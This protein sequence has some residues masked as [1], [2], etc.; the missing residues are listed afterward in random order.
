MLELF[1]QI[2]FNPDLTIKTANDLARNLLGIG[3]VEA[4]VYNLKDI[5]LEEYPI[6]ETLLENGTA[7]ITDNVISRDVLLAPI[8][9]PAFWARANFA[10]SK[11]E[12]GRITLES[13]AFLSIDEHVRA[14]DSGSPYAIL[15]DRLHILGQ[16]VCYIQRISDKNILYVS[17]NV[18]DLYGIPI[19]DLYRG[20]NLKRNVIYD[21]QFFDCM[22]QQEIAT[23]SQSSYSFEYRVNVNGNEKIIW[24]RGE[25]IL[26][27]GCYN[28]LYLNVLTDVT[29]ERVKD[30]A[31]VQ[32][33]SIKNIAGIT[34]DLA[35]NFNNIL[36][37]ITLN[38]GLMLRG[39][40]DRD[41]ID[42]RLGVILRVADRARDI[43]TSLMAISRNQ[44]LKPVRFDLNQAI[45][46]MKDLI[47]ASAGPSIK[48]V[49]ELT[50]I[51]CPVILDNS[52]FNQAIFN[53]LVNSRQAM[54]SG[55]T[56]TIS[57][58][59]R[60]HPPTLDLALP[61]AEAR[62]YAELIIAD[63][64]PG[65]TKEV[66]EHALEPYFTTKKAQGGSGIGLAATNGFMIQSGGSLKLENRPGGGL[67]VH[68]LFPL[69][70]NNGIDSASSEK[71]A[72]DRILS[73]LVVDDDLDLLENLCDV[74]SMAGLECEKASSI[75]IAI[76]LAERN[77][78]DL[79]VS[80]IALSSPRDGLDLIK[81]FQTQWPDTRI[82]LM[83]GYTAYNA[84]IPIEID[85][86]KKPFQCDDIVKMFANIF[87]MNDIKI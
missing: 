86:L 62:E 56:I 32:M 21:E 43:T 35:H 81:L 1:P 16:N 9:R 51:Q 26:K 15:A 44:N 12:D 72:P 80:D 10:L 30:R 83:S 69:V 42:K 3:D 87:P 64:G 31:L 85:F 77:D 52:G 25:P 28:D 22:R 70:M 24:H 57:S 82:I 36:S 61:H 18:Q 67:A 78:F 2:E 11:C 46:Q 38:C 40:L 7:Q 54:G 75:E 5:C 23:S 8:G 19:S 39:T 17:S 37:V 47:A 6:W 4:T 60:H 48:I 71:L 41:T 34:A 50:S 59:V 45:E 74:L 53:L 65:M 73:A 84:E 29:S 79:L 55:G 66:L 13:M 14:K 27:N 49:Y 20:I 58:G 68:L 76:N 63:D 33:E